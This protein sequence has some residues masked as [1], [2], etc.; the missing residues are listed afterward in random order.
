M[1]L[2]ITLEER[3]LTQG[4]AIEG[5]QQRQMLHERIVRK[6]IARIEALEQ[7]VRVL[8]RSEIVSEYLGE[9]M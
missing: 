9:R 6:L 8:R 5:Y 4:Q 1:D 3:L 7:E 2:I